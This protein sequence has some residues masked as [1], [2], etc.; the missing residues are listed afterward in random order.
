MNRNTLARLLGLGAAAAMAASA[1]AGPDQA[2]KGTAD[3]SDPL[4]GPKVESREVPGVDDQFGEERGDRMRA[5][6]RVPTRMFL[7]AIRSLESPETPE[8]LQLSDEQRDQIRDIAEEF[9]GAMQAFRAEHREELAALREKAPPGARGRGDGARRQ[10]DGPPPNQNGQRRGQ[11][12]PDGRG[13]R[14]DN[15]P[16]PPAPRGAEAHD[17]PPPPPPPN[18][19]ARER[20]AELMKDAPKAEP[21]HT[22]MWAVLTEAQQVVVRERL[23]KELA[24]RPMD[25]ARRARG[26]PDSPDGRRPRDP[27]A[28][29]GGP[30]DGPPPAGKRPPPPP[31]PGDV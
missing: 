24:D 1:W 21:Y 30:Q 15:A 7:G 3:K 19:E 23:D 20:L 13:P 27:N 2:P 31:P 4:S 11:G 16:P 26:G 22:R 14:A 10:G 25:G 6:E 9:R 12:P 8:D 29:R 28:R 18:A 5:R 17:G